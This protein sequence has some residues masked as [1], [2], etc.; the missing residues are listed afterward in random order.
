[1]DKQRVKTRGI[2]NRDIG[3]CWLAFRAASSGVFINVYE[4]NGYFFSR[5]QSWGF[6]SVQRLRLSSNIACPPKMLHR[7]T[8][9]K[10]FYPLTNAEE[11][12]NFTGLAPC[13][14]HEEL[15]A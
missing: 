13:K 2:L 1:M 5:W 11:P 10:P 6:P 12:K 8:F 15:L 14:I 7:Q 3:C 4:H 9:Q